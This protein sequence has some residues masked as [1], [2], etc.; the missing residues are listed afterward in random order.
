MR[1]EL[2]VWEYW[3]A[4]ALECKSLKI[5]ALLCFGVLCN[6][7]LD[8]GVRGVNLISH[9]LQFVSEAELSY[10]EDLAT[11]DRSKMA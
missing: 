3:S 7:Q 5:F 2:R 8:K 4:F 1:V 11:Y 6:L 10:L 9:H